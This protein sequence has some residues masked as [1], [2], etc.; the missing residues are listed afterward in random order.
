MD[1]C[2]IKVRRKGAGQGKAKQ[3]LVGRRVK[4]SF[5]SPRLNGCEEWPTAV[6]VAILLAVVLLFFVI[7]LQFLLLL[8]LLLLLFL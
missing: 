2:Q 8:L 4:A 6:H 5:E 1:T 3:A 7:F